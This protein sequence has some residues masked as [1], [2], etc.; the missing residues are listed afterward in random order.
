VVAPKGF[1]TVDEEAEPEE[2]VPAEN[3]EYTG[4]NPY[5]GDVGARWIHIKAGLLK[6]GRVTPAAKE[7]E[8][9]EEEGEEPDAAALEAKK[10]AEAEKERAFPPIQTLEKVRVYTSVYD[11][12]LRI[13]VV[14][15]FCAVP[16]IIDQFCIHA[17]MY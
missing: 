15:Y 14:L 1:L 9:E 10:K 11:G 17:C 5:A 3:E 6:Q 8:E 2:Q 16:D 4:L 7:E 13:F 12:G